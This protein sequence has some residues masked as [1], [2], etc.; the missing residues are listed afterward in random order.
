MRALN[1]RRV[2][3]AGAA[4][5]LAGLV[6][7]PAQADLWGADLGP[8]TT[9]VGQMITQIAQFATQI[10]QFGTM[11]SN[12]VNMIKL[13]NTELSALSHGNLMALWAFIQTARMAYG[14]LTNNIHSMAYTMNAIDADFKK[15]F[16]QD[17]S[18][19][20][21]AQ[22]AQYYN[23]WN[24]EV[25]SASQIAARQQTVLSTLDQQASQADT[26]LQNSQNASG[27]VAELQTVVQMLRL[28]EGQLLTINQSLA[29][30]G[31]VLADMAAAEAS[32]RQMSETTKQNSLAGYTNAGPSVIV[33]HRLP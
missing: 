26:V 18:N 15:L 23:S 30:A 4:V 31:R 14:Q 33:L 27:V 6:P 20:P 16:P 3:A 28:M 25:L 13:M 32:N 7:A 1:R 24:T 9:I 10:G 21:V 2:L 11:I 8:L 12:M 5:T 19:I 29:T 17:T 22:R